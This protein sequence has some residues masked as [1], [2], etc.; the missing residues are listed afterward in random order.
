MAFVDAATAE[1]TSAFDATRVTM[2]EYTDDEMAAYIASG[3][4]MDKAGAYA[5]QDADF[6]PAAAIEGCWTNAIGLPLCR[7]RSLL[8]EHGVATPT[9]TDWGPLGACV[10]CASIPEQGWPLP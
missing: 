4:P 3:N 5:A 7:V 2:R 8:A 9:G 10:G 1:N 6:H